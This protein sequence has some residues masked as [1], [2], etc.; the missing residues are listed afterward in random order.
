MS[1]ITIR[2]YSTNGRGYVS[3]EIVWNPADPTVETVRASQ[4]LPTGEIA[5]LAVIPSTAINGYIT[6][7]IYPDDVPEVDVFSLPINL[8]GPLPGQLPG[9]QLPSLY[10]STPYTISA[11]ADTPLGFR[12]NAGLPMPQAPGNVSVKIK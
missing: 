5:S 8:A 1:R 9:A 3:A 6:V 4:T 12:L 10:Y 2:N 11:L 7:P